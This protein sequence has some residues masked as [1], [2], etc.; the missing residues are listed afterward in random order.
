MLIGF[1]RLAVTQTEVKALKLPAVIV[2]DKDPV[3]RLYV[4]P[5]TQI[6]PDWP[7]TKVAD[8]GHITCIIKP[9]F[10]DAVVKAVAKF[11]K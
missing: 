10:R 4:V 6:R 3:D 9:E 1:A 2:G 5:L 7:V 11:E 8:A